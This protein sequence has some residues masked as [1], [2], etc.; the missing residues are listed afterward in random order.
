M[1]FFFL[2]LESWVFIVVAGLRPMVR[3]LTKNEKRE[4][5]DA[6]ATDRRRE[7]KETDNLY[8]AVHAIAGRSQGELRSR[9][10]LRV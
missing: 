6:T 3:H 4:T 2:F 9:L 5:S 10:K 8:V 1:F 7:T